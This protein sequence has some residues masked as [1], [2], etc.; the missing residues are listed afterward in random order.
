MSETIPGSDPKSEA[1]SREMLK[2]RETLR[3][4]LKEKVAPLL[5]LLE[6]SPSVKIATM[7]EESELGKKELGVEPTVDPYDLKNLEQATYEHP[8]VKLYVALN[9][10]LG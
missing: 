8:D 6:E 5:K 4:A 2:E 10:L 1:E 9:N 7:L 3:E